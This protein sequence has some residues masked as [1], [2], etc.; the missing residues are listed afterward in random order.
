M[1]NGSVSQP[2]SAEQWPLSGLPLEFRMLEICR[3]CGVLVEAQSVRTM[4]SGSPNRA[5]T[6]RSS[7][8]DRHCR[9]NTRTPCVLHAFESST[10]VSSSRSAHGF[11]PTISK[12]KLSSNRLT[13]SVMELSF[14]LAQVSK[15]R[16][17]VADQVAEPGLR[18]L[19][20][21]AAVPEQIGTA[22]V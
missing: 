6:R 8:S 22:H 4:M 1:E 7:S 2:S 17:G 13:F 14:P 18:R 19:A 11:R 9:R 12:A 16:R 21:V 5:L 15:R 10:K 20:V 3:T